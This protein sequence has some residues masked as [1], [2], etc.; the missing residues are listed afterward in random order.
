M[1]LDLS[2]RFEIKYVLDQCERILIRNHQIK[3]TRKLFFYK[4]LSTISTPSCIID[5]KEHGTYKG[6]SKATKVI[7]LEKFAE[8]L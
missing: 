3:P 4:I 7:I 8:L 2:Y 6:L 5:F 1:L